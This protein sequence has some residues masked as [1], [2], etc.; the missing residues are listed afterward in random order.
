MAKP[1]YSSLDDDTLRI[2][3]WFRAKIADEL[4]TKGGLSDVPR[5]QLIRVIT[6]LH[7]QGYIIIETDGDRWNWRG[8][9]D[10]IHAELFPPAGH[11]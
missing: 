4:A 11:A 3:A 9:M 2:L 8:G 5:G 6:V 10:R 7:E 1:D